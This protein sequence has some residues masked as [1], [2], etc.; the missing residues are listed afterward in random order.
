M[1]EIKQQ[2]GNLPLTDKPHQKICADRMK[3]RMT[4]GGG[5]RGGR[6]GHCQGGGHW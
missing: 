2:L 5:G 4:R 3:L 1:N 6:G